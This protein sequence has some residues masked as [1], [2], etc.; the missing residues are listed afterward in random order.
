MHIGHPAVRRCLQSPSVTSNICNLMSVPVFICFQNVVSLATASSCQVEIKSLG[1][2]GG[3]AKYCLDPAA[4]QKSKEA[5]S[6]VTHHASSSVE[7]SRLSA[8][9]SRELQVDRNASFAEPYARRITAI[10]E[11]LGP[12]VL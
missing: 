4:A 10:P 12:V 3:A 9:S 11:Q 2:K 8:S 6:E 1:T 7:Q 5:S